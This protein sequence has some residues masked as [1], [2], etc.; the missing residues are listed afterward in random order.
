MKQT[1][2]FNTIYVI[3]SLS[4]GE[5]KTG[6]NVFND[7]LKYKVMQHEGFNA[8]LLIVNTKAEFIAEINGIYDLTDPQ[9]HRP[10]LHFEIHGCQQGLVM[11]S[12]ELVSW[13]E[14]YSLLVRI[15]EML[16]NQLFISLAT[17]YGA[18][19]FNAINPF[20]RSPFFG[21]VGNVEQIPNGEIEYAFSEYFATLLDE[22]DLDE[23][24][25]A[26]NNANPNTPFPYV[27][28]TSSG[29]YEL[30]CRKMNAKEKVRIVRLA[31]MKRIEK[32]YKAVLVAKTKYT[33]SELRKKIKELYYIRSQSL[34]EQGA[35]F[36]FESDRQVL[37]D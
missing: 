28:L 37:L 1:I 34:I 23:A 17:C 29:L 21:F 13:V 10:Y 36:R 6:T 15:N 30:L 3:E 25:H 19:L 22:L 33:K 2:F 8:I 24:I 32:K 4:T 16:R 35:Y 7:L 20:K 14:L 27:S 26:L 12:G 5:I 31:T 11:N 9:M 18:Y